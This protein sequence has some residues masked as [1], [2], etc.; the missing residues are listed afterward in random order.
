MSRRPVIIEEFD[1]D[2]DLPLPSRPLPNTGARGPLLEEICSDDDDDDPITSSY[3]P[4]AGPATFPQYQPKPSQPPS[5]IKLTD[6]LTPN[7]KT[8][9][10][11]VVY[12]YN[13]R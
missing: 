6:R 11:L 10:F 5:G 4:T 3:E 9:V 8:Y 13:R 7:Q 12:A 1:D 2:T